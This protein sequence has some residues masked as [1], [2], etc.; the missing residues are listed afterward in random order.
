M[1]EEEK[2]NLPEI[3]GNL[4]SNFQIAL[5]TFIGMPIAGSI[6][7]AQNYRNLGRAGSGWQTLILGLVSTI[8]LFIIAFLLPDGFPNF[9]LPMAY[10]I[11]MRQLV[12]YLQ[13]DVIANQKGSWAVTVGV[14]V[15]CLVLIMALVFGAIVLF[16]PE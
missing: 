14:A 8:V 2:P 7:L 15:G 11:A 6:L 16:V 3:T 9:I 1:T 5:A 10:T 4:F 12:E 13:G